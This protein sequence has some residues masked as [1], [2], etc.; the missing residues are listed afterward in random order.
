MEDKIAIVLDHAII[1]YDP[2][3]TRMMKVHDGDYDMCKHLVQLLAPKYPDF[4]LYVVD[5]DLKPVYG[6]RVV[7]LDLKALLVGVA[8]V[9]AVAGWVVWG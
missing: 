5:K 3:S 2:V 1:A 7:R 8:L 6:L 9:L 4:R